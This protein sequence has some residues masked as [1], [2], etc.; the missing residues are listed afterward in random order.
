MS[1]IRKPPYFE[2]N[3]TPAAYQLRYVWFGW[4][5]WGEV[6]PSRPG[7]SVFEKLAEDWREDGLEY[8][9]C[10]WHDEQ[11]AIMVSATPETDP[12][13]IAGRLKGRLDHALR[14]AGMAT[15]FA[16]N[17][18]VRSVGDPT[19]ETIGEYIEEQIENEG[20]ACEEFEASLRP[21]TWT[22]SD[23][24]LSEPWR[25]SHGRYWYGLHVVFVW[26]D[27]W[28]MREHQDFATVAGVCRA[29]ARKHDYRLWKASIVPDHVHLAVGVPGTCTPA[30]VALSFM[31]NIVHVFRHRGMV[32]SS[33]YVGTFGEYG[34]AAIRGSSG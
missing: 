18:A 9:E 12:V 30:S 8:L 15:N 14:N 13:S 24:N 25:S 4:P 22:N 7:A 2:T 34:M 19:R 32:R 3:S 26:K 10:E 16:R 5:T 23:V 17:K 31:N 11:I 20:L 29:V 6:F 27:R 33:Y 28:R 21:F 1:E